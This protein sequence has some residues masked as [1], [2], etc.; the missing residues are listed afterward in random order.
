[1]GPCLRP[2]S[3][4]KQ[5]LIFFVQEFYWKMLSVSISGESEENRTKERV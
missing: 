1:M 4:R 5:T 2:G 3:L